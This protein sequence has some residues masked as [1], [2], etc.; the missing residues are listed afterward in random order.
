MDYYKSVPL[1]I[2]LTVVVSSLV[3]S[4]LGY[5]FAADQNAINSVNTPQYIYVR[6]S[7]IPTPATT[8]TQSPTPAS[9][10]GQ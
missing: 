10:A 8:T 3:F 2:L 5:Y 9:T 7:S 6:T 4:A 1:A